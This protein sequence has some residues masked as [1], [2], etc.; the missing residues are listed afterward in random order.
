MH[1]VAAPEKH[2]VGHA[3]AVEMRASWPRIFSGI[4]IGFRDVAEVVHVIA[5][6]GR[7]VIFVFRE[8][9]IMAWRSRKPFLAGG[10]GRFADK[11]FPFEKIGALESD[12]DNDFR[13]ARDAV[14]IPITGRRRGR[15]DRG[16]GRRGHFHFRATGQ[17]RDR[18]E[19]NRGAK[20]ETTAHKV[21]DSNAFP[22]GFNTKRTGA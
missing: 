19:S 16:R 10:D 17:E 1:G 12:I 21:A 5:E 6:Y 9:L 22:P 11:L 13:R 20:Q 14:A 7:D 8:H 3:R 18:G 4:D 2:G 15:D